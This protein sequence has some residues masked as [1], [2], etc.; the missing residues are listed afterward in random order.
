MKK[1]ILTLILSYAVYVGCI[2]WICWGIK[3]GPDEK[4]VICMFGIMPGVFSIGIAE[5]CGWLKKI[6]E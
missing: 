2:V 1:L 5:S 4:T 3:L 6:E